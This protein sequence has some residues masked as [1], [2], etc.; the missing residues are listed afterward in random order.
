MTTPTKSHADGGPLYIDNST[1]RAVAACDTQAIL[2][3]AH[4]LTSPE[5]IAV[6][7]SGTDAHEALRAYFTGST[8]DAALR[9][10]TNRYTTWASAN[11]PSDGYLSRL[12]PTNLTTILRTWFETHP[13]SALP[14]TP[15]RNMVEIPF[16]FPLDDNGDIIYTGAL[17]LV[18]KDAE[19]D[20]APCDHKTTGRI[21]ADWVSTFRNDSQ[22]SGYM[23]ACSQH[24]G[25]P[26]TRGY[27]NAIEFSQ[28]PTSDRKCTKHNLPF[29]ECST[30]HATSRIILITRTPGQITKWKHDALKLARRYARW[31]TLYGTSLDS[32]LRTTQAGSFFGNCRFCTFSEFCANGMPTRSLLSMYS[33]SHWN[34]LD[35]RPPSAGGV[36]V[37]GSETKKRGP[38]RP[39]KVV[40]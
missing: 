23:W 9:E 34:P 19:V 29:S 39:K 37:E 20:F 13:I 38:G 6:L 12:L 16:Q 28:L 25:E 27:V 22:F 8:P 17:D 3:Y 1:L 5:E 40:A 7:K 14:F 36:A 31:L 10:F 26:V 21:S 15:R 24:T 11:V 33:K 2:R 30:E 35:R 4:D 32:I 18:V